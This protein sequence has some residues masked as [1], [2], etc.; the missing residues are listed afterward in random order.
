MRKLE[1]V[2]EFVTGYKHVLSFDKVDSFFSIPKHRLDWICSTVE[3]DFDHTSM[4]PYKYYQRFYLWIWPAHDIFRLWKFHR[5]VEPGPTTRPRPTSGM[6]SMRRRSCP[7]YG[8]ET[9]PVKILSLRW[10]VKASS[11][12]LS[13][14]PAPIAI[15]STPIFLISAA[16]ILKSTFLSFDFPSKY[17]VNSLEIDITVISIEN[18]A[19]T[20]MS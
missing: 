3:P 14:L 9:V 13:T 2:S 10:S 1:F 17:R 7:I 12:S 4:G 20:I 6:V 16:G 5:L 11:C 15:I 18:H 19:W 8:Y